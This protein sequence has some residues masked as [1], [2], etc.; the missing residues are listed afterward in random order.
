VNAE[1]KADRYDGNGGTAKTAAKMEA[2]P[3]KSE[4]RFKVKGAHRDEP[5]KNAGNGDLYM[6]NTRQIRTAKDGSPK[7]RR[8]S[9]YTHSP[10][11][12]TGAVSPLALMPSTSM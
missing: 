6:S 12:I 5:A 3:N 7:W 2:L 11:R 8:T 9:A 10:E 4:S 1:K